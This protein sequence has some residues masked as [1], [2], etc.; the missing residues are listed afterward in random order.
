MKAGN[1]AVLLKKELFQGSKSF[2]VVFAVLVPLAMALFVSLAFGTLFAGKASLGV[3]AETTS[4]FLD[5]LRDDRG[6]KVTLLGTE[7][8][9]ITAV[10]DGKVDMGVLLPEG[11]DTAV[12]RGEKITVTAY[13]WGESLAN[14]RLTVSLYL[15]GAMR[16]LAGHSEPP[17]E[18]VPIP[19]G[20]ERAMPWSERLLPLMVLMAV[21]MT[22]L[23]I[24]GSSLVD[25][26][27]NRTFEALNVTQIT[28]GEI[29]FTK[30][31]FGIIVGMINGFIILL[32]NRAFGNHP[33]FLL[34]LL[35]A[36]SVMMVCIGLLIG[37]KV[38]D[39]TS[40]F[41]AMKGLG[42]FLFLPGILFLFPKIPQWI[43]MVFPTYY[44]I[45]PLTEVTLKGR[46]LEDVLI[47]FLVLLALDL[48]LVVI[49]GKLARRL[50]TDSV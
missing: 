17:V 22:G 18:I 34:G 49:T 12:Q 19:V 2:F 5:H 32:I 42:F 16:A 21:A 39:T 35:L 43:S 26:K 11:L 31:L 48:L 4:A 9:L 29:Y 41:A 10:T 6:V 46:G 33:W 8:E 15:A 13:V 44:L 45:Y 23:A 25:E 30:A 24:S 40:F 38:K 47:Q 1:I 14:D 7:E 27:I 36:G 50:Q 3:Y 28:I 20:D 37:S